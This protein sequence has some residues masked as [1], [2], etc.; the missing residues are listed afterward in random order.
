MSQPGTITSSPVYKKLIKLY[1]NYGLD[2]AEMDE[3]ELQ[4]LIQKYSTN[5]D[6]L[7]KDLKESETHKDKFEEYI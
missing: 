1:N 2:V 5:R 3:D 6:L 4:W 7:E